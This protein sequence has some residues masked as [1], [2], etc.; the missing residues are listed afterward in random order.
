[1]R[2]KLFAILM[3]AMMMVTFMPAMAF[4]G[5]TT[6]TVDNAVKS[7]TWASDNMSATLEYYA[8][9]DTEE[10]ATKTI[11]PKFV[12]GSN[13][14]YGYL[15]LTT[16]DD[17]TRVKFN[18][19]ETVYAK[20]SMTITSV[21][22]VIDMSQ[23][24]VAIDNVTDGKA[25]AGL[26][27]IYRKLGTTA[28]TKFN[29]TAVQIAGKTLPST[30][31]YTVTEPE[32]EAYD[33]DAAKKADLKGKYVV[34]LT[35]A[36]LTWLK[37]ALD[38]TALFVYNAKSE[39]EVTFDTSDLNSLYTDFG[40]LDATTASGFDTDDTVEYAAKD[41]TVGVRNAAKNV[42]VTYAMIA[43]KRGTT[44]AA[45]DAKTAF[46]A[47]ECTL[48]TAPTIRDAGN[49][50]VG[51]HV[52]YTRKDGTKTE[53]ITTKAFEITA[54]AVAV[55]QK[56]AV[57][58]KAYDGKGYQLK[59]D[60]F[61]VNYGKVF[62]GDVL[63][64]EVEL[65]RPEVGKYFVYGAEL[66]DAMANSNY[67]VLYW[68]VEDGRFVVEI[69]KADNKVTVKSTSVKKN[70]KVKATAKFGKVTFKKVSGN[71]KIKVSKAGKVT[72]KKG[73]KKGTYKVKVKAAVAATD[74][75]AG[76]SATKTIKVVVK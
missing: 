7:V 52:V 27:S 5:E 55:T 38:N 62:E 65:T 8:K 63:F 30:D 74:N 58:K 59:F 73:L 25:D 50:K 71:K 42:E 60:D 23:A 24:T 13:N 67:N 15:T 18:G 22:N 36:G 10:V 57:L 9:A 3:S 35:S 2:K 76:A 53:M 28:A 69:T 70:A 21:S 68:N 1:M 66:T 17:G 72:V 4:A 75:Y 64:T 19:D 45:F 20:N 37:G 31:Y 12:S 16:Y 6:H 41:Y 29:V 47:E 44:D 61:V 32:Y 11:A 48:T 49:Y 46:K 54:A 56:T 39:T 43:K 33:Y 51:C 26:Y 14:G 34:E 40:I